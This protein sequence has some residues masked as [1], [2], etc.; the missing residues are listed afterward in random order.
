MVEK[1]A[2]RKRRESDAYKGVSRE[3]AKVSDT[4]L[5]N[6]ASSQIKVTRRSKHGD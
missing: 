2:E 4:E 6:R 3:S 1:L 5:F